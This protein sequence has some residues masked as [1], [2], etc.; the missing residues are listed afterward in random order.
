MPSPENKFWFPA[1]TYG[2]GWGPPRCWQGWLTMAIYFVALAAN[3]LACLPDQH[4]TRFVVYTALLTLGLVIIAWLKG[5]K[6]RWRWGKD[7][8]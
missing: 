2:Y 6:P 7:R 4:T 5:E 8:E 3:A 1:K